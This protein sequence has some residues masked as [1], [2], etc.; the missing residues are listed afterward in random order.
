MLYMFQYLPE[1]VRRLVD[2]LF[3][4]CEKDIFIQFSSLWVIFKWVSSF[5]LGER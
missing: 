3:S 4:V 5:L 1:R 2:S